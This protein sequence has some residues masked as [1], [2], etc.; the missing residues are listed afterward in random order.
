MG[1]LPPSMLLS[2]ARIIPVL[3]SALAER[4][5]AQHLDLV[6]EDPVVHGPS[7]RLLEAGVDGDREVVDA[8]AAQAADVVMAPRVA[9]EAGRVPAR[10]DLADHPR[11]GQLLEVARDGAQADPGEAAAGRDG[12]STS[13]SASSILLPWPR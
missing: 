2:L 7:G 8:A 6:A 5:H 10:V 12:C 13:G 11:G 9:V 1:E 3:L 4:T